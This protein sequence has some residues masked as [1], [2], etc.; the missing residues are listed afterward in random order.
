MKAVGRAACVAAQRRSIHSVYGGFKNQ[1]AGALSSAMNWGDCRGSQNTHF[2]EL[3]GHENLTSAGR[4]LLS[5]IEHNTDRLLACDWT[6]DF[7]GFW[8]GMM[9]PPPPPHPNKIHT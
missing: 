7:S 6:T 8:A 5:N 3:A 2:K 9:T 4:K 1:G